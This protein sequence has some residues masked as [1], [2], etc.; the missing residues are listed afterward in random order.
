MDRKKR[1]SQTHSVDGIKGEI[2]SEF[3]HEYATGHWL[4]CPAVG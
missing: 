2:L 1:D 3:C 4:T